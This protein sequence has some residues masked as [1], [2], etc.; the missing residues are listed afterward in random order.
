M[1]DIR[2]D[3]NGDLR[4]WSCGNKHFLGK[5]TGRA[6]IAGWVTFTVGALATKKKLK[7]Q[8]CNEY[9][10]VGN[11][12]EFTGPLGRK[13]RK[14][15]LAEQDNANPTLSCSVCGADIPIDS[16]FCPSC[17]NK[18]DS[19]PTCPSCGTLA[20]PEAQFCHECGAAQRPGPGS[21]GSKSVFE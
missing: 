2:I 10:Q 19:D 1:Q 15:W 11:A 9:N 5:R 16:K 12:K 21:P 13:Y 3:D 20:Q 4:C 18:F 8:V 6:H 14:K 7:C 17:G